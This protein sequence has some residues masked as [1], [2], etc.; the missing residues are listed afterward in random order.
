[1]TLGLDALALA[2]LAAAVVL[3]ELRDGSQGVVATVLA[4]LAFTVAIGAGALAARAL[5][6]E[7]LRTRT[8]RWA[9]GLAV[10]FTASFPAFGVITAI[11]GLEEGWAEPLMPAQFA[12]ALVA[13]VLGLAAREPERRGALLVPLLLGVTALM[14]VVVDLLFPY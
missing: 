8:G 1:M 4:G 5:A 13:A 9:L 10:V 7:P 14:F 6:R 3:I 2:A 12:L 11:L